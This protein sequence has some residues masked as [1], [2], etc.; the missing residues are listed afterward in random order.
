MLSKNTRRFS[1]TKQS[2]G[3]SCRVHPREPR[4]SCCRN[5]G[6]VNVRVDGNGLAQRS[7]NRFQLS[8]GRFYGDLLPFEPWIMKFIHL[9]RPLAKLTGGLLRI[10]PVIL[11]TGA[12]SN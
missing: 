8:I 7:V 3:F 10:K 11:L 2:N 9:A 4:R 5:V 12:A 1:T 6:A